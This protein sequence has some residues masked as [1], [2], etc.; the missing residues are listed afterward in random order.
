MFSSWKNPDTIIDI[1][2]DCKGFHSVYLFFEPN[3]MLKAGQKKKNF[4]Q[5][6]VENVTFK[7]LFFF[8]LHVF[9]THS[10]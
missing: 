6:S 10:T 4:K 9:L 1:L 3:G 5:S 2:Q 7:G 8:P